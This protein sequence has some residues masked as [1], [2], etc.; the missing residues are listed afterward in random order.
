MTSDIRAN[1]AAVDSSED[2]QSEMPLAIDV[3]DLEKQYGEARVVQGISFQVGAGE[4]VGLLGPN[5]AGKTTTVECISGLRTPTRGRIRVF[6]IDPAEDTAELRRLLGVQ[7]QQG[8]L[9]DAMT[10]GQAMRLFASFYPDPLDGTSLIERLNLASRSTARYDELSGGQKQRLAVA[11]ALIGRP[12]IAVLDELTTGLDPE[13]RRK[14]WSL[15]EELRADGMTVL[16]VSHFMEE[17]ERLC[18]RVIL[19]QHGRVYRDDTPQHLT[20]SL[21]VG[22]R[23]VFS[24]SRQLD[25]REIKKLQSVSKVIVGEGEIEVEG[26]DDLLVELIL[27]LSKNNVTPWDLRLH[28]PSLD[29][30]YLEL[31][32]AAEE[33]R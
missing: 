30:A 26:N 8:A 20:S 5:G 21:A 3:Q 29:D 6:G 7:L 31:I 1:P 14:V 16:L 2:G 13:A 22:H 12:R 15:I 25:V 19:L 11:L 23:V 24:P 18:D 33:D 27:W 10:V 32:R 9:P 28:R 4:V 17:V